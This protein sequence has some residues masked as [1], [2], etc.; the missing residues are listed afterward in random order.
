MFYTSPHYSATLF[1]KKEI[2][3]LYHEGDNLKNF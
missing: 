2:Y 1:Q 3:L